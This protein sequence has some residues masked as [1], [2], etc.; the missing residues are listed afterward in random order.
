MTEKSLRQQVGG[1]AGARRECSDTV[2]DIGGEHG[3]RKP[4]ADLS[5]TYLKI[6]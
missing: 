5:R 3:E 2:S 1:F 4:D 6:V